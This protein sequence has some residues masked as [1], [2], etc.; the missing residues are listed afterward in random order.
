MPDWYQQFRVLTYL[1]TIL[2]ASENDDN[3]CIQRHSSFSICIIHPNIQNC[4]HMYSCAKGWEKKR[5]CDWKD[6]WNSMWQCVMYDY[7]KDWLYLQIKSDGTNVYNIIR[8]PIEKSFASSHSPSVLL[9]LQSTLIVGTNHLPKTHIAIFV[10]FSLSP[11]LKFF[12]AIR[13]VCL[14]KTKLQNPCLVINMQRMFH[15]VWKYLV[16]FSIVTSYMNWTLYI[17]CSV[18]KRQHINGYEI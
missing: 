14:W 4:P 9:Y 7:G 10:H 17:M 6:G 11:F 15:F 8:N 2:L 16:S 18:L 12:F 5:K 13:C 1:K 3:R